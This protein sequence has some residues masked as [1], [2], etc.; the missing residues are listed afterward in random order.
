MRSP[1]SQAR[2]RLTVA[3]L[4]IMGVAIALYVLTRPPDTP[5][6][7]VSAP[8]PR[9]SQPVQ[10]SATVTTVDAR[11][12]T[13]TTDNAARDS[14]DKLL[15]GIREAH[16]G[17]E[18]WNDAGLALVDQLGRDAIAVT[19]RGCY[20]AGCMGTF[21]FASDGAYR[22]AFSELSSS[23]DYIAWTGGK[24]WTAPETLANGQVIV[25]LVLQ[26]PD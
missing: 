21:T 2:V 9:P 5:A 10:P 6:P 18:S 14:R 4:A 8:D 15:D 7:V 13:T 17:Q 26:R 25:A 11:A 20:M 1:E 23:P 12:P 3:A 16:P 24:Q 19:D 22:R